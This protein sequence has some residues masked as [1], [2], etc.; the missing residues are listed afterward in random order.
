MPHINYLSLMLGSEPDASLEINA[1]AL[2]YLRDEQ[3]TQLARLHQSPQR[4]GGATNQQLLRQ[5]LAASLN[6]TGTSDVSRLGVSSNNL[7]MASRKY[8]EKYGLMGGGEGE[9]VLDI[10][11]T[12]HLQTDFSMA[13]LSEA[14]S[15]GRSPPLSPQ[16]AA[17]PCRSS[18]GVQSPVKREVLQPMFQPS[19]T[20]AEERE[21][22]YE[23]SSRRREVGDLGASP[24][25]RPPPPRYRHLRD[26][27][28]EDSPIFPE[29]YRGAQGQDVIND[30]SLTTE[31][32]P[33]LD[34]EKLKQMP[35]LL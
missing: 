23:E 21:N 27:S 5:F 1:M 18:A 11:H 30:C 35:K 20:I 19:P 29:R 12:L 17:T 9:S 8:M 26:L 34:I 15:R 2:K 14:R 25:L 13:A 31:D 3:L 7:S 32:D 10:N 22:S 16:K 24:A 6:T 33:I 28:P 4:T